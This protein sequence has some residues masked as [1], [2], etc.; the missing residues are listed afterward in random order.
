MRC[1]NCGARVN[2]KSEMCMNCGALLKKNNDAVDISALNM[3][4]YSRRKSK[5]GGKNV[6]LIILAVLII[7]GAGFASFY[8]SLQRDAKADKPE[9]SFESGQGIINKNENVIYLMIEDSSKIQF[10][11]GAKLYDKNV[12][13]DS[14]IKSNAVDEDYQYTKNVDKS[15]RA[16]FFDLDKQNLKENENYTFTIE[17]TVSFVDDNNR[18]TYLLPVNFTTSLK[19]DVS[20]FVFD[21][22]IS[23]TVTD[24]ALDESEISDD[25]LFDG[26]WYSKQYDNKGNKAIYSVKFKNDNSCVVTYYETDSDAKC[27]VNTVNGTFDKNDS[28]VSV[29]LSNGEELSFKIDLSNKRVSGSSN[30][31]FTQR[32]NNSVE[33]AEELMK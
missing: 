33:N 1:K 20:E 11:H 4:D 26:Y 19:Q 14:V 16:V 8:F 24:V 31:V 21:H 6:F 25:F 18:Y 29:K 5:L 12:E 9:L 13:S 10:I 7:V 30:E 28:N 27:L 17:L 23:Q 15:I 2:K 22:S 32:Q 3:A